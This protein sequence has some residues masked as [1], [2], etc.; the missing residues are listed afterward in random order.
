MIIV[1]VGTCLYVA[2]LL[3]AVPSNSIFYTVLIAY[4]NWCTV[5]KRRLVDYFLLNVVIHGNVYDTLSVI[6]YAITQLGICH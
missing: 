2:V 4:S 3:F 6:L 1:I 5:Y